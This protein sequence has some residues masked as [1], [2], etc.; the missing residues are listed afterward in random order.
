MP[1][2]ATISTAALQHLLPLIQQ[3]IES[4]SPLCQLFADFLRKR[5]APGELADPFFQ[6]WRCGN[7]VISPSQFQMIRTDDNARINLSDRQ[8]RFIALLLG[9]R[10]FVERTEYRRTVNCGKDPMLQSIDKSIDRLVSF[11]RRHLGQSSIGTIRG[12]G[13][14]LTI[15]RHVCEGDELVEALSSLWWSSEEKNPVGNFAS[16]LRLV[17]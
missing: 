9:A 11:F 1:A 12:R 17:S 3:I 15:E 2:D 8:A 5:S 6:I 10:T 16:F 4:L 13:H 14:I 7:F